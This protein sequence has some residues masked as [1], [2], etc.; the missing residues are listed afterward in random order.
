MAL[1][2]DRQMFLDSIVDPTKYPNI[3]TQLSTQKLL[4]RIVRIV[5]SE[6]DTRSTKRKATAI[7]FFNDEYDYTAPSDLKDTAL[8]DVIPQKLRKSSERYRLVRT[9]DFDRKKSF[10]G[11]I[12]T[13]FDADNGRRLR[14]SGSV[15]DIPLTIAS[16]NATDSGG[17]TWS[18]FGN[19]SGVTADTINYVQGGGSLSFDLT[20]GGTTSGIVNST[21]TSVDLSR[22]TVDGA[23]FVWVYI[24]STANITNFIIRLG[25]SDSAYHQ[26]TT[27][28]QADGTAFVNGW[29]LLRFDMANTSDTGTPTDTAITYCALYMTKSSG[30]TGNNYRFNFLQIHD[31]EYAQVYYYSSYG[32]NTSATSNTF[33]EASTASSDYLVAITDEMPLY[34]ACGR[35]EFFKELREYDQYKIAAQEYENEK[36]RYKRR[37]PSERLKYQFNY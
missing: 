30:K 12:V 22:Y 7:K 1:I 2:Y 31:G 3:A 19:A 23:V 25:S 37:Y 36:T 18:A 32:W 14:F 28:T 5:L 21:L 17:G 10:N 35:R 11:N 4:N 27:T 8:I 15:D 20:G 9:E 6:N 34:E 33:I 24:L 16:L 13:V 29:N 26:V